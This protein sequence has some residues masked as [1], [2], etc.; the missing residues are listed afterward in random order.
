MYLIYCKNAQLGVVG[1]YSMIYTILAL[2]TQILHK[3]LYYIIVIEN[4]N[5]D[6]FYCLLYCL[7]TCWSHSSIIVCSYCHSVVSVWC[8]SCEDVLF[9]IS[10]SDINSIIKCCVSVVQQ[11]TSNGS[12]PSNTRYF[13]P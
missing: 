9:V 11:V 8:R 4:I 12:I 10:S 7:I 1:I 2:I 5:H 6:K 3:V 13:L